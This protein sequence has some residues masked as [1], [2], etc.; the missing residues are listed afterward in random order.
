MCRVSGVPGCYQGTACM[1]PRICSAFHS[2]IWQALEAE[3][4]VK[5]QAA[6]HFELAYA[7]NG[8]LWTLA[9]LEGIW[10]RRPLLPRSDSLTGAS[11]RKA[12]A[13]GVAEQDGV[14]DGHVST[15]SHASTN[16]RAQ[17]GEAAQDIEMGH[18]TSEVCVASYVGL[19][20]TQ[21]TMH[22]NAV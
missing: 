1:L 19:L 9:Y 3:P 15:N 5:S 22:E 20:L 8:S 4:L 2:P 7:G 18:N 14:G 17:S 10:R 11:F 12:G 13:C 16:G 6:P 21:S